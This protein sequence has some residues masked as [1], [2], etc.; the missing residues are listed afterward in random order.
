MLD[1]SFSW[2]CLQ[3]A[4]FE[5]DKMT[6]GKHTTIKKE[7]TKAATLEVVRQGSYVRTTAIRFAI[8]REG[9]VVRRVQGKQFHTMLKSSPLKLNEWASVVFV[10]PRTLQAR[11]KENRSFDELQ[12]DR[13]ELVM[14]VMERGEE[15]F[16][17]RKKF[18]RWLDAPRPALEDKKPV[19][20]LNDLVGI[21]E[22]LA[23][24]G[25]IEHG[26]F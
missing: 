17:D 8:A 4:I 26:V 21:G 11:I 24:L 12:S 15:V 9:K 1:P 6:M 5:Q 2:N 25:R 19:D 22:V 3:L 20:M 16:G 18:R 23:E 10:S 13:M 7:T 14:H